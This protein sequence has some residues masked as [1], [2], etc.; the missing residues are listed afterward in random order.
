MS[1][2]RATYLLFSDL[3]LL[4]AWGDELRAMF[5]WFSPMLTGS[6]LE[7]QSWRD[8]D[9]R[10]MVPDDEFDAL[11]ALVDVGRLDL[12]LS[13]W[14]QKATGLP[15]DCQVQRFTDANDEYGDRPRRPIRTLDPRPKR[16]DGYEPAPPAPEDGEAP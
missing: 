11:A 13:L 4:D 2:D 10:I 14:G 15:I 3:R 16:L 1:D 7:R 5:P 6:T 8:V 9:V 12:A